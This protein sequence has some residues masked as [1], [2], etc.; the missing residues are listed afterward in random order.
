MSEAMQVE[1]AG[2]VVERVASELDGLTIERIVG[3]ESVP[4]RRSS[5]PGSLFPMNVQPWEHLQFSVNSPGSTWGEVEGGGRRRNGGTV[6]TTVEVRWLYGLRP[7]HAVEDHERAIGEIERRIVR[8]LVDN[9]QALRLTVLSVD[10]LE[11][12]GLVTDGELSGLWML[13][14]VRLRADHRYLL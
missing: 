8:T 3:G 2:H 12:P 5:V 6:R 7:E 11:D 4:M 9:L 10:R 13:G 1:H 14:I